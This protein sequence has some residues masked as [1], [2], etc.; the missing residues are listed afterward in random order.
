L[1]GLDGV[2]LIVGDLVDVHVGWL[3]V[4]MC[5]VFFGS[6]EMCWV[7]GLILCWTLLLETCVCLVEFELVLVVDCCRDMCWWLC[8]SICG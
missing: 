5:W 4:W 3:L 7:G 8:L 6:F 1:L 2:S